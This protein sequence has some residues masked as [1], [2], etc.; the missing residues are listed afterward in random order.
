ML[1]NLDAHCALIFIKIF[2]QYVC[3]SCCSTAG[4]SGVSVSTSEEPGELSE[5][6]G[7]C[8][9]NQSQQQD[10]RPDWSTLR[11]PSLHL[12]S[13]KYLILVSDWLTQN[14]ASL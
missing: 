14:N 5:T 11:L 13:G 10:H 2:L 4:G 3:F 9:S 1:T 6:E 12:Q 8:R 7:R